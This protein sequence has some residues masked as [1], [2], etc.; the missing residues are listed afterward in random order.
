MG[1]ALW[2]IR[3]YSVM[4]ILITE[5]YF[6]YTHR[7]TWLISFLSQNRD[8]LCIKYIEL[9][10]ILCFISIKFLSLFRLPFFFSF[11][12]FFLFI[13]FCFGG[14]LFWLFF[15]VLCFFFLLLFCV[16]VF[17][18]VVLCFRFFSVFWPWDSICKVTI[19]EFQEV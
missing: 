18:V 8:F 2:G 9:T 11:I 5:L 3:P 15:F 4:S 12:S 10:M 1:L 16:F 13:F 19:K 7:Y 14:F 17:F 6:I